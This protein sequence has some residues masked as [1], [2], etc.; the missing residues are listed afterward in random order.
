MMTV[1][2]DAAGVLSATLCTSITG[3]SSCGPLTGKIVSNGQ[4][5]L[6]GEG[7]TFKGMISGQ[8]ACKDGTIGEM[9]SGAVQVRGGTGA[10][11]FN[12]C[13]A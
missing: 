12:N 8:I 10:F 7:I 6:R 5:E 9:I 13:R 1:E 11:G 3:N 4:F 2:Q